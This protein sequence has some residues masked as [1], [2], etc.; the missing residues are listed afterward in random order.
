M[1]GH[2]SVSMSTCGVL[3][4]NAVLNYGENGRQQGFP[5]RLWRGEPIGCTAVGAQF[6]YGSV[7]NK[8]HGAMAPFR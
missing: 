4:K 6:W 7:R 5:S 8:N 1:Q 3:F 2:F